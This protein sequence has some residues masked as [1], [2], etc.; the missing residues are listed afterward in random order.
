LNKSQDHLSSDPRPCGVEAMDLDVFRRLPETPLPPSP[1]P[2][3]LAYPTWQPPPAPVVT[4]QIG[5][6]ALKVHCALA[7]HALLVVVGCEHDWHSDEHHEP[8]EQAQP[9]QVAALGWLRAHAPRVAPGRRRFLHHRAAV[10]QRLATIKR[11]TSR[12]AART[13][14]PGAGCGGH[15][16]CLGDHMIAG[17]R[18][19]LRIHVAHLRCGC[20]SAP[21]TRGDRTIGGRPS[22]RAG[23]VWWSQHRHPIGGRA[24]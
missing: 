14:R 18:A 17:R 9:A 3:E 22:F 16:R 23:P 7:L 21:R 6:V 13:S 10:R 2:F 11:P 5:L 24:R 19:W 20:C 8:H 12:C 4:G 15:G 1:I